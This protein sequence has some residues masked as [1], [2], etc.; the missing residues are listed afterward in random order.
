[1]IAITADELEIV[2]DAG[3]VREIIPITC[4]SQAG[5]HVGSPCA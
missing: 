3:T 1:M 5:N 4:T 2:R